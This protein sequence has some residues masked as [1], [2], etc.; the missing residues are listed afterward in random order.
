MSALSSFL[1]TELTK[2]ASFN[3][4]KSSVSERCSYFF[5]DC[6]GHNNSFEIGEQIK[7]IELVKVYKV[8]NGTSITSYLSY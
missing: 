2:E 1:L 3:A 4:Q 5:P 6:T 8:Y 7:T